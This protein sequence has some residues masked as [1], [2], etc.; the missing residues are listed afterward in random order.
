MRGDPTDPGEVRQG[1]EKIPRQ[2]VPQ[3]RRNASVREETLPADAGPLTRSRVLGL[4]Q[5]IE[6]SA[7]HQ[8]GRPD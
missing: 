8:V 1:G 3:E 5:G 6:E 2:E 7:I 4:M